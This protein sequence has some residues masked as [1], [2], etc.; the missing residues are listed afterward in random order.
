M[1][2]GNGWGDRVSM[3]FTAVFGDFTAVFLGGRWVE[4]EYDIDKIW[5]NLQA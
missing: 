3:D 2:W 1:G 5:R 4:G